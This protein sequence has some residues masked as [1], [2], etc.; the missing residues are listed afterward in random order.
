MAKKKRNKKKS[1]PS[2]LGKY[3]PRVVEK[4]KA[5]ILSKIVFIFL[6]LL[7]MAIVALFAISTGCYPKK[8]Y[9]KYPGQLEW[10]D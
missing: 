7:F 5:S 2:K 3:A 6:A 9:D 10:V 1:I 8:G 4:A